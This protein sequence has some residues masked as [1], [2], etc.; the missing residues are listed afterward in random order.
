M[1]SWWTAAA[2]AMVIVAALAV[3]T[4]AAQSDEQVTVRTVTTD[5]AIVIRSDGAA[6]LIKKGAG[7][8]SLRRYEGKQVVLS[9]PALF[10]SAGSRLIIPELGQ[11]CRIFNSTPIRSA[12]SVP[13]V[14]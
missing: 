4:T 2:G 14:N 11:E 7:C 3:V 13:S 12:E 9:G 6:Y 1:T 5:Q 10:P 8:P